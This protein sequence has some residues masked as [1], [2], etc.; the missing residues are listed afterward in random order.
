MA[1]HKTTLERNQKIIDK[2]KRLREIIRYWIATTNLGIEW[3]PT[4]CLSVY[5][6]KTAAFGEWGF[7]WV[8]NDH[9]IS[10]FYLVSLIANYCKTEFGAECDF[11]QAGSFLR[12]YACERFSIEVPPHVRGALSKRIKIIIEKSKGSV[13][14]RVHDRIEIVID[15]NGQEETPGDKRMHSAKAFEHPIVRV[16]ERSTNRSTAPLLADAGGT[17]GKGSGRGKGRPSTMEALTVAAQNGDILD[18]AEL[19][20]E[21]EATVRQRGRPRSGDNCRRKREFV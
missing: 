15:P 8:V 21:H 16:V 6:K 1:L 20:A 7:R 12:E 2:N 18:K 5:E 14:K 19:I 9:I 17:V 3:L 11:S 13:K 10:E 4:E